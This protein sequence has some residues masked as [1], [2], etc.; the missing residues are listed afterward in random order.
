MT[1]ERLALLIRAAIT[2]LANWK[3][4]RSTVP[5]EALPHV[6]RIICEVTHQ[7]VTD[8]QNVPTKPA[9][10]ELVRERLLATQELSHDDWNYL[11]NLVYDPEPAG[12]S[13]NEVSAWSFE[14][15]ADIKRHEVL[16]GL[17]EVNAGQVGGF[18]SK[19]AADLKGMQPGN[20][21]DDRKLT[22]F[23]DGLPKFTTAAFTP[24]GLK[25]IDDWISGL[26]NNR[27]YTLLGPTGS[28][29]TTSAMQL[30]V[31]YGN[32]RLRAW[33]RSGYKVP[34]GKVFYVTTEDGMQDIRNRM[35]ACAAMVDVHKITGESTIP[36]TTPL[37]LSEHD[38]S[39]ASDGSVVYSECER[40]EM[41]MYRLNANIRII[42]IRDESVVPSSLHPIDYMQQQIQKILET[43]LKTDGTKKSY[44]AL[45]IID[46]C[47]V[48]ISRLLTQ[49]KKAESWNVADELPQTIKDKLTVQLNCPIWAVHQLSGKANEKTIK[50]TTSH[51]DAKRSKSWG[52]FFDVCFSV[53]KLTASQ[54]CVMRLTKNRHGKQNKVAELQLLGDIGRLVKVTDLE[55]EEE[56][57]T[58]KRV[59]G[60][61]TEPKYEGKRKVAQRREA[62]LDNLADT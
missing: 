59:K 51:T 26:V 22:P 47:E 6:F 42:D 49:S 39:L 9:L 17:T 56:E 29:K 44:C 10:L 37:T 21:L 55:P 33:R 53:S 14:Y 20:Y 7:S 48:L 15:A 13:T 23:A 12:L 46:H 3:C 16:S 1:Q 60:K 35:L 61:G 45:V 58:G 52:T 38:K 57:I 50:Q 62:E 27:T 31:S 11:C 8:M 41:A 36:F 30:A 43:D 24:T 5:V 32:G 34:L 2:N 4:F 25:F 54:H 19:A 40:V 28:C 18:L